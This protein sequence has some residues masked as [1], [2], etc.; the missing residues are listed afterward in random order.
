MTPQFPAVH[1]I[2]HWRLTYLRPQLPIGIP[3]SP[4][5]L[6]QGVL[7]DGALREFNPGHLSQHRW[8]PPHWH[9]MAVVQRV[10]HSLHPRTE[11]MGSGPVLTRRHLRM[12]APHRLAAQPAATH[13]H[14]EQVRFRLRLA[15]H[16]G[17]QRLLSPFLL[18]VQP[19]SAE[20]TLRLPQWHL[21]GRDRGFRLR[22]S[23]A[24]EQ[25]LSR[26][27]AWAF[28]IVFVAPFGER[29][30]APMLLAPQL[31]D[32]FP[33]LLILAVQFENQANQ[34]GPVE[35]IQIRH[36]ILCASLI[37]VSRPFKCG[38]DFSVTQFP[39]NQLPQY[40]QAPSVFLGDQ[41]AALGGNLSFDLMGK[42]TGATYTDSG[43][44]LV[45]GGE[46]IIHSLSSNIPGNSWAS[47]SVQLAPAGWTVGSSSG[48]SATQAD[49]A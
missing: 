32:L 2:H 48:P 35:R 10:G 15:R 12:L 14:T 9:T 3:D 17:H 40:W 28:G 25:A 22:R 4:L 16:V 39:A 33:Q 11:S 42:V 27:S 8:Q 41:S 23:T 30:R 46:T 43:I 6:L 36:D 18:R 49:L 44:I 1:P 26:L 7:G 37:V 21:N 24:I 47:Y 5:G 34:F 20:R 45:G 13:M 38:C 31:F 19:S 29:R